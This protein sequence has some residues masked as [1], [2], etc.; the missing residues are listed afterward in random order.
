M[1]SLNKKHKSSSESKPYNIN[2]DTCPVPY[3]NSLYNMCNGDYKI[4]CSHIL[5]RDQEIKKSENIIAIVEWLTME[6]DN[7]STG[8]LYYEL[9]MYYYLISKNF[10]K[11]TTTEY[12]G[13]GDYALKYLF[14]KD[15]LM[16]LQLLT[17]LKH[18]QYVESLNTLEVYTSILEVL[19]FCHDMECD[20]LRKIELAQQMSIYIEPVKTLN[21][22]ES[23]HQTAI[24]YENTFNINESFTYHIKAAKQGSKKSLRSVG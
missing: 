1:A 14:Q 20:D 10:Q 9:A 12:N 8:T 3:K 22:M 15:K 17:S 6:K 24:F 16:K 13:S 21:T 4:T 7:D 5:H 23:N 19:I 2:W 18:L 11:F